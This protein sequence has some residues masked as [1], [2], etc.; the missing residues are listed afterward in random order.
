MSCNWWSGVL[1]E[2]KVYFNIYLQS[3]YED[4]VL[5]I[6]FQVYHL[7]DIIEQT[8]YALESDSPYAVRYDTLTGQESATVTLTGKGGQSRQT[9]VSWETSDIKDIDLVSK[10]FHLP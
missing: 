10:D 1:N 4:S 5:I 9:K 3:F 6:V 2:I 8:G 7:E